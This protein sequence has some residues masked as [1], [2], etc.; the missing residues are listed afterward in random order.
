[1]PGKLQVSPDA[2]PARSAQHE[3]METTNCCIVGGGPAGAVLALLLARAGVATTLLEAH[4]DFDREF[5]GD[6][7]HPS[8]L[9]LMD[10]L[11]LLERL[12]EIPHTRA[13]TVTLRAP[14]GPECYLDFRRLASRYPY[15][16]RL[17]QSRFLEL[18]T[19]EAAGHPNF[20]LVMGARVEELIESNGAIQGVRY[21]DRDGRHELSAQLVVGADGRF[22]KVRELA[23]LTRTPSAQP[24]D[25]L[26]FRLPAA[27]ADSPA[28]GGLYVGNGQYTFVR[29]RG[30]YW[31]I[32]YMLPKGNYQRLR[33][34]GLGAA[35]SSIDN[36]VPWLAD[37]TGLL[38]EW[39]QT[40]LLSIESSRV[41]RWYRDGLLVIGDAAHVMSPVAGVGINLAIQDA[42][43]AANVLGPRLS[44]GGVRQPDLATVQRR[45]EWSTRAIQV[46]QD[47]FLEYALNCGARRAT[48]R[49]RA[50]RLFEHL[51]LLHRVRTRLFAFGGL[52]PQRAT[53]WGSRGLPDHAPHH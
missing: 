20:Q 29:N 18:L 39:S 14:R 43:V 24:I 38:Q 16:L 5:R 44:K 21:R 17:P 13:E 36:L 7:I 25:I 42:V 46:L 27:P 19:T 4:A 12:L 49:M 28:N 51:P 3:W 40:S 35:R 37:R 52:W 32:A 45:R 34:L 41:R 50:V 9:E 47:L 31:Q 26:W 33:T 8:T 2:Q 15:A 30:D 11:G 53:T 1:M 10:Q 23:G 22:S 48:P 6:T